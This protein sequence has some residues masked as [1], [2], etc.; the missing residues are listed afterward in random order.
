MN[1][2]VAKRGGNQGLR[3]VRTVCVLLALAGITATPPS[4]FAGERHLEFGDSV[5][6]RDLR[7]YRIGPKDANRTI[8]V[9]GSFHGDE[10]E[11]QEIIARL[12][13]ESPER[14]AIWLVESVNP[15]G[16]A[17]GSRKNAHGV[18]LNRN[19]SVGWKPSSDTSSGY[20]P[21]P[22]PFSEPESRAVKRLT[23]RIEPDLSIFYHQPWNQVLGSCKGPDRIQRRYA[24]LTSM[25]FACRGGDLP[26]TAT[27]WFNRKPGRR[28]FVVELAGG[29]LSSSAGERHTRA[30]LNI[31]R[32]GK[33]VDRVTRAAGN[34]RVHRPD[35]KKDPIPYG[36]ERKRQMAAYSDRHYGD[37]TWRL[38]RI[39]QIVIHYTATSTYGPVWNTFAS[40]SP[41]NGESPG[42]C[43]QF[44]VDKDGTI[45]SL[46]DQNV[47]CRHAIGLN[48]RSIGLEMV[49]ESG[50][51]PEQAILN[52]RSQRRA[53]QRLVAWLCQ[54]H[55]VRVT[56]VIGH[57][58]AN[59]SRF[60]RDLQGWKN[61][62]GDWPE[63]PTEE[64]R[65]GVRK[66]RD[67]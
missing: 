8:L 20:Y 1:D 16:I 59:D 9:V 52:R 46:V 25:E 32:S 7:A 23:K 21:G 38:E 18:D 29:E 66:I 28:A 14:A 36:D 56:D 17:A 27:K 24:R 61:D 47:R 40:N 62:H 2:R 54:R 53:A 55:E 10:D 15:D 58:M 51:S 3:S 63:N 35:M 13:D 67:R 42:V 33:G 4:A 43:T 45:Y 37:R 5:Q 39:D 19:F 26:G 34:G 22:E 41:N 48:H 44:V 65:R 64:F 11:G 30:V 50:S 31:A 49:Q 57:A 60:F 12:R 6:G